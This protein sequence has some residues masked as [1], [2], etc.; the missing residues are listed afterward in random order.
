MDIKF[1]VYVEQGTWDTYRKVLDSLWNTKEEAETRLQQIHSYWDTAVELFET[2][3]EEGKRSNSLFWETITP[4]IEEIIVTETL[5]LSSF[6]PYYMR[7]LEKT[8]PNVTEDDYIETSELRNH[9]DKLINEYLVSDEDTKKKMREFILKTY[10]A[11]W[12]T[13]TEPSPFS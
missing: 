10:A 8:V 12:G 2:E 1:A 4:S 9:A 5:E 7:E 11:A 13:V 6:L 3:P